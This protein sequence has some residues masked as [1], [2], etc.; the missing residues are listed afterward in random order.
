MLRLQ[1]VNERSKKPLK[2]RIFKLLLE[3]FGMFRSVQ[4]LDCQWLVLK[5][6]ELGP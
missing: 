4:F 1:A 2:N 6:C 5:N 3:A